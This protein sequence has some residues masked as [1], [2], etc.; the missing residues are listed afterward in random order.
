MQFFLVTFDFLESYVPIVPNFNSTLVRNPQK[1]TS[2]ISKKNIHILRRLFTWEEN[3]NLFC[4]NRCHKWICF[5]LIPPFFS[6]E[7]QLLRRRRMLKI[8]M[9]ELAASWQLF[10]TFNSCLHKEL[11]ERSWV[12]K[13]YWTNT[14]LVMSVMFSSCKFLKLSITFY[15]SNRSKML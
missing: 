14:Y 12:I 3:F 2:Y 6:V 10:K 11:C 1:L 7:C 5:D 15:F 13:K 4:L 8:Q 9:E